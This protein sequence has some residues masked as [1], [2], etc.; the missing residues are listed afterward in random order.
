MDLLGTMFMTYV[1]VLTTFAH[2]K[3]GTLLFNDM[4]LAL[5]KMVL[6]MHSV[7]VIA[8]KIVHFFVSQG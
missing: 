1:V 8:H 4:F 2:K 7:K 5:S 3:D 6:S